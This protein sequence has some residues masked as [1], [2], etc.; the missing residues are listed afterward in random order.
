M[1]GEPC[2]VRRLPLLLAAL[3]AVAVVPAPAEAPVPP[4]TFTVS[5]VSSATGTPLPKTLVTGKW[6]V[7]IPGDGG[8]LDVDA[9]N[10]AGTVTTLDAV[11]TS[12]WTNAYRGFPVLVSRGG[13]THTGYTSSTLAAETVVGLR[14]R[15]PGKPWSRW[16]EYSYV[17]EAGVGL[18]GG[19]TGGKFV[20]P[21]AD[22][23]RPSKVQLQWHLRSV[24]GDVSREVHWWQLQVV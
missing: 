9:K 19:G 5:V 14:Y 20:V 23:K 3:A 1:R 6:Y 24:L 8:E 15:Y 7:D 21:V 16:S 11:F 17:P 2:S 10:L 4:A 22:K 12:R 18:D 13:S